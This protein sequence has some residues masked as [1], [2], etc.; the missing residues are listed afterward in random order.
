[1]SPSLNPI[2]PI[3]TSILSLNLFLSTFLMNSPLPSLNQSLT[4]DAPV[5]V[6]NTSSIGEVFRLKKT[7]GRPSSTSPLPP[8][9]ASSSSTGIVAIPALL[10]AEEDTSAPTL[11]SSQVAEED[12][13]TVPSSA[14]AEED[15]PP[16]SSRPPA[17][18]V[19]PSCHVIRLPLSRQPV[20]PRVRRTPSPVPSREN[21]RTKYTPPTET[22]TRSGRVARPAAKYDA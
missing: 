1:M 20:A 18:A 2:L 8:L 14:A 13:P 22:T 3:P 9:S 16:S 12:P 7:P 19:A 17:P 15:P 10:V 5:A 11:S 6:S 21:L 4:V